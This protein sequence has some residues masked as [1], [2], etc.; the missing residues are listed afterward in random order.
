MLER[1]NLTLVGSNI[2]MARPWKVSVVVLGVGLS[3]AAC[4]V[5]I[6]VMIAR[7]APLPPAGGLIILNDANLIPFNF[8][9]AVVFSDGSTGELRQTD[10]QRI[11]RQDWA[12]LVDLVHPRK[13]M[14]H[15]TLHLSGLSFDTLDSCLGETRHERSALVT[16]ALVPWLKEHGLKPDF[17]LELMV[18]SPDGKFCRVSVFPA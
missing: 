12:F 13:K 15:G 8:S 17:T 16:D 5:A 14:L 2:E 10:I 1:N 6:A 7:S 11:G 9:H 18:E 3:I 4:A